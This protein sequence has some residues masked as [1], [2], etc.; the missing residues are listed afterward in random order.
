MTLMTFRMP[1]TMETLMADR[2]EWE[3][4][5]AQGY[6]PVRTDHVYAVIDGVKW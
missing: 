2:P 6:S 5:T 4:P 3:P 1:R